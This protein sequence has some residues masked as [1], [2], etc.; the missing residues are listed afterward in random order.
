MTRPRLSAPGRKVLYEA[1]NV[2]AMRSIFQ[3]PGT[4]LALIV[5]LATGATLMAVSANSSAG[6]LQRG[7]LAGQTG[8][9]V[10]TQ[11]SGYIFGLDYADQLPDESGSAVVA[12]V[13]DA[14]QVGAGWIRV[15][16]AWYRIQPSPE[17]WD[18]SSFDRT[19]ATAHVAGL[20]VLAILGQPPA[21]AR[22]STCVHAQ[23]CPPADDT[24]FAAFAAKAAQR[25]P[26]TE[27]GAW[28]V[29]NEENL[30][31]FWSGGPDPAAYARLLQATTTALLAVRPAAQVVLGGLA[32]TATDGTKISPVD[33]L[34]TVAGAGALHSVSAIG[35]HPYTFPTM[36][37]DSSAF[38]GL[39][40]GA[41]S[42]EGVLKSAGADIPIWIT[43]D[44]AP[45]PA[46]AQDPGAAQA[47]TQ[48][49]E[50]QQAAYATA[51]IREATSNPYVKAVFWFSDIDLPTQRLYY[52]VRRANG[53]ARPSFTA[54]E[55][56]IT[57][58]RIG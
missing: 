58:Y 48:A 42:L 12:G 27:V 15:D 23:W 41:D 14:A 52:G 9:T 2:F 56:A 6:T 54:L 26:A 38:T 16:L 3:R 40:A 43:E 17:T 30:A 50:K 7:P 13:D 47:V 29:W 18:W 51:L 1:A 45:V 25:Y 31:G 20:K 55:Q 39:A 5:L 8:R 36:P 21:W 24:Q 11:N 32:L 34:R 49:E 10:A 35:Y 33:F 37:Q 4:W 22:Q 28:E 46:A 57:A 53:S 44:G 19:V